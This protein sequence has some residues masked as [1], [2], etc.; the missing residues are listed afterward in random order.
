MQTSTYREAGQMHGEQQI[1]YLRCNKRVPVKEMGLSHVGMRTNDNVHVFAQC[2][3]NLMNGY[4]FDRGYCVFF[5]PMEKCNNNVH[6]VR[7]Y[8]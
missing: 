2:I 4:R 5:S 7:V 8:S 1:S 6:L 3:D